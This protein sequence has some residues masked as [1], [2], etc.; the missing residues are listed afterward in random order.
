MRR[1]GA[2]DIAVSDG[3]CQKGVSEKG[4]SDGCRQGGSD[5]FVE[6]WCQIAL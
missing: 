4:L 1:V 2:S 5:R 3:T 6:W